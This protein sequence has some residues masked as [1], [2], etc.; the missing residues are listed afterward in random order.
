MLATTDV[1]Q[2]ITLEDA[3]RRYGLG[4]NLLTSM[5]RNGIIRAGVFEERL[6]LSEEDV[7]SVKKNPTIATRRSQDEV[8]LISPADAA[9][10]YD[11]PEG[12]LERLIKEHMVR[13]QDNGQRMLYED[14]VAALQHL[15][16][17]KFRHLEDRGITVSKAGEQYGIPHGTISRWAG[18]KKI[19]TVARE[20]RRLYVNESDVAYAKL[21]SEELGMRKGRGIL[22]DRIY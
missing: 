7:R 10:K 18:Q 3:T 20:G 19:R 8:R 5:V 22:P 11:I 6:L 16:R 13:V 21:L 12:V 2:F 15:S 4:K 17:R 9:Q 14:D 1:S